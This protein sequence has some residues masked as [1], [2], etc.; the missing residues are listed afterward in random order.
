MK[1]TNAIEAPVAS[2]SEQHMTFMG[3]PIDGSLDLFVDA[4]VGK[5]FKLA[6]KTSAADGSPS[7]ALLNGSFAGFK[8]CSVTVKTAGPDLVCQVDVDFPVGDY[9]AV[10]VKRYA[11]LASF[12]AS[13]YGRPEEELSWVSVFRTKTGKITLSSSRPRLSMEGSLS[14]SY[15]DKANDAPEKKLTGVLY[16][17]AIKD[18]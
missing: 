18:L 11:L 8:D 3:L 16:E 6:K 1:I 7:S 14:L 12:L 10:A 13:K 4:L 9:W 5:G 2:S 17:Q 15:I